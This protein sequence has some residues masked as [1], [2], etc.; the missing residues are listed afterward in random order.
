MLKR[1]FD[2]SGIACLLFMAAISILLV[3][4]IDYYLVTTASS[5]N[6]DVAGSYTHS[7]R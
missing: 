7:F 3:L 2:S 5:V 4:A 6:A 1:K